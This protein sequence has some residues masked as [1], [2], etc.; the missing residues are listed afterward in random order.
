MAFIPKERERK[1]KKTTHTVSL[2]KTKH[3]T[4]D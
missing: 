4:Q 2:E 1:K 3:T